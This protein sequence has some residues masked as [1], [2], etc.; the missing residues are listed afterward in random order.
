[1][2]LF[3]YGTLM[4]G[5]CNEALMRQARFVGIDRTGPCF[6]LVNL[7]PYPGLLQEGT[8]HVCGEVYELDESLLAT[9]DEF[10]EHPEVYVRRTIGLES[11]GSAFAYVLRPEHATAATWLPAGDWR[12]RLG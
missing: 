2:K 6:S 7:G 12:Q 8:T 9:L 3:V 1:M 10:E 5:E 4:Q 11:G